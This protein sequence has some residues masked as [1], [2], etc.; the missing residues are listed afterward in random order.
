M[1]K[2]SKMSG[3]LDHHRSSINLRSN[4]KVNFTKKSKWRYE[5]YLKSPKVRGVKV[6][7]MLPAG[8]E[9]A[10]TKVKFKKLLKTL[11]WIH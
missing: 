4:K 3:M 6:W 7:E 2:Q 1:C 5:L 8:V 11:C 10:T 9:K